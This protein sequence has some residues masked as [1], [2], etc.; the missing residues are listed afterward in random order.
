[1]VAENKKHH[2]PAHGIIIFILVVSLVYVIVMF[3]MAKSKTGIF[4]K[5]VI[6]TPPESFFHPLGD[7]TPMTPDE[8][9]IKNTV[10]M[11]SLNIAS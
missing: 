8:I 4:S 6:P 10:I 2:G 9:R 11:N 5:Y 7:V 1:M 3:E